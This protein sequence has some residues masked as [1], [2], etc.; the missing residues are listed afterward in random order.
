MN[1]Y[2]GDHL[3]MREI[4]LETEIERREGSYM[5]HHVSLVI[6]KVNE[7]FSAIDARERSLICMNS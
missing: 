4:S 1:I 5:A 6:R 3:S 2:K 7:T